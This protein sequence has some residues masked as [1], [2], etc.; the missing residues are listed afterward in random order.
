MQ[1]QAGSWLQC[2]S[3]AAGRA[4][5]GSGAVSAGSIPKLWTED[6][7]GELEACKSAQVGSR[8]LE[9]GRQERGRRGADDQTFTGRLDR[10][11]GR[12]QPTA[13]VGQ[14]RQLGLALLKWLRQDT[15]SSKD[16]LLGDGKMH[17]TRYAQVC[18]SLA[19]ALAPARPPDR[20]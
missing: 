15:A 9:S 11:Q 10:R 18:K 12:Q 5:G 2:S 19:Q 17:L 4:G 6:G 13:R 14:S 1:V 3:S 8:G 20:R 7:I 16:F